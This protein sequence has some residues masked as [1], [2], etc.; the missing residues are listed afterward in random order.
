MPDQTSVDSDNDNRDDYV[1]RSQFL[2]AVSTRDKAK[3]KLRQKD[4]TISEMQ[5]RLAAYEAKEAEAEEARQRKAGEF[6]QLKAKIEADAA[7]RMKDKDKRIAELERAEAARVRQDRISKFERAIVGKAKVDPTVLS[8]LLLK[9]EHD[10]VMDIAPES[11][12][13]DSVADA[14]SKL[15]GMSEAAFYVNAMGV[16]PSSSA[17]PGSRQQQAAEILN[18]HSR[19][20]AHRARY[21]K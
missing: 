18:R 2:D 12:D 19:G 6:D 16:P 4:E 9:A 8:G 15:R 21:P 11:F 7:K 13:D 1:P 20:A 17:T 5:E 14:I 10:G 3:E